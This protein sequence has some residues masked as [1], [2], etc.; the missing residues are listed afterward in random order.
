[1]D[2][3]QEL[4]NLSWTVAVHQCGQWQLA[5]LRRIVLTDRCAGPT[6]VDR[7]DW[8]GDSSC[9][10]GWDDVTSRFNMQKTFAQALNVY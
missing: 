9:E 8:V 2:P 4:R 1:M 6:I 3:D 10:L 7:T 5:L